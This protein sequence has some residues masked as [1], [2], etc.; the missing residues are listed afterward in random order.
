[1]EGVVS[2]PGEG[3]RYDRGDRVVTIRSDLPEL[4]VF[5][6]AFDPSF[7]VPPHR[8]DD[9]VE[10]FYV[11]EGEVEF[12][13][14][15]EV[16]RAGPGTFLS[17]PPGT[18]HGFLDHTQSPK[19]ICR[20]TAGG[21]EIGETGQL[22]LYCGASGDHNHNVTSAASLA[23]PRMSSCVGKRCQ[24]SRSPNATPPLTPPM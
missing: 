24:K 16:V 4:S 14:E 18:L 21:V 11:L 3:E 7:V 8:H 15:N 6:I 1:M 10:S 17:A 9:Q 23:A 2:G 22:A 5:E 19:L 13:I 12:T 20:M